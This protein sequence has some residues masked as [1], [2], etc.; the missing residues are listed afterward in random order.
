MKKSCIA[1]LA[2]AAL[3]AWGCNGAGPDG[4]TPPD[5]SA[6]S[7]GLTIGDDPIP[8][9]GSASGSFPGD[10]RMIGFVFQAQSGEVYDITLSR[11]D[12]QD[13]PA[14]VLYEFED[15]GWSSA[16][17]WASADAAEISIGGWDVPRPG[18]YLIMIDVVS[19]TGDGTFLITLSCTDGCNDPLACTTDSDCPAGMVCW[20]GLCFD[21]NVECSSDDDCLGHEVCEDGFCVVDC[22]PSVEVCDGIDNDC[23][24]Q[25]DEGDVCQQMPCSSDQ[26]CP[27]REVCVDGLCQPMCD[28]AMDADCP[29]GFICVNCQCI[30]EDCPDADGDGYSV[31]RSDCN[32]QD[33]SIHPGATEICDN[34]D[35]DCDG[36]VD[37]G[38]GGQPCNA[39]SD[40][41]AGELCWDGVCMAMCTSNDDCAAG[42]ACMNGVCQIICVPEEEICDGRDNDCDGL[43]DEGFDLLNDPNNCG[44]CQMV[45]AAGEVCVQG[46]CTSGEPCES[47]AD[48]DDGNAATMDYCINGMCV[49]RVECATDS[50]CAVGE[51]CVD[52]VCEP[53]CQDMDGDGYCDDDCDDN[54]PAVHPGAPEICDDIDNDCD[55][56]VDENCTQYCRSNDE[57]AAGQICVNGICVIPCQ[58]DSDCAEGQVCENGV[59]QSGCVPMQEICDGLDNDC[60]GLVDEDFDF[61]SDPF[62][63]G[64]CGLVCAQGESCVEGVCT[65][66]EVCTTDRDCD[67]GNPD[68]EDYCINGFCTYR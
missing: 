8:G 24:G 63:C 48:C 21:Q 19:G 37:E 6:D 31:C 50:D 27:P 25:I 40:C 20:N 43:V 12:G 56:V 53:Y 39:D 34:I 32:D 33:A 22:N 23:D 62:N 38:C 14:L 5:L 65:N 29:M 2:I 52:G 4:Y 61:I 7:S 11:T 60:D 15:T 47:D 30:E 68:T 35:N 44:G 28:C 58:A 45:C 26:D 49:H 55:G 13:V 16:L 66:E 36:I 46:V 41:A 17:A 9:G 59:C 64:G 54:N 10:G 57:C 18:T 3:A 1:L 51:I 42:Q 67:D